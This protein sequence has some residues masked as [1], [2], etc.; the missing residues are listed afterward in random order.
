MLPVPFDTWHIYK[1]YFKIFV[2]YDIMMSCGGWPFARPCKSTSN[3]PWCGRQLCRNAS[4]RQLDST[5]S[6]CRKLLLKP[7]NPS[8]SSHDGKKNLLK[9]PKILYVKKISNSF[10]MFFFTSCGCSYSLKSSDDASDTSPASP[11]RAR[12]ASV[13]RPRCLAALGTMQVG[14][15]ML[16]A[17][18]SNHLVGISLR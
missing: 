18:F 1:F 8:E 17:D 2:T 5:E 10:S 7:E 9:C 12:V 15:D 11:W 6:S 16:D 13:N 14:L 4:S 3:S